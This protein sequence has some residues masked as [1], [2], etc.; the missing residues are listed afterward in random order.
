MGSKRFRI[1][2]ILNCRHP[3]CGGGLNVPEVYVRPDATTYERHFDAD[4]GYAGTGSRPSHPLQTRGGGCPAHA[5]AP[6]S[7]PRNLRLRRPAFHRGDAVPRDA[8]YLL[9]PN[10]W[11]DLQHAERVRTARTLARN[12]SLRREGLVRHQDFY[13]E[14]TDELS[15]I[16]DHQL[17]KIE[18]TPPEGTRIAAIDVILRLKKA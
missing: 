12:R 2:T 5:S 14:D 15:D 18:I 7:R 16:P 8:R 9:R 10:A 4:P 17:P 11:H 1:E 6:H 13:F 3:R